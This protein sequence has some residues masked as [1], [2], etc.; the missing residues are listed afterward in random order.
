LGTVLG[1]EKYA[2]IYET[3]GITARERLMSKNY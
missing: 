1:S 3:G 2:S